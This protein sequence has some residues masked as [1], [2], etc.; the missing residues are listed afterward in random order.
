MGKV[1]ST[2]KSEIIRLAKK[3]VRA[4][5]RPLTREVRNMRIKLSRLSKNVSLFDR[6]AKE[7]MRQEESKKLKL[8][9]PPEQVKASRFTPQRIGK[10]RQRLALSQRELAM[11]TGV[12]LGAVGSWEKGKFEPRGDKKSA[13]LALKKLGRRAVRKIL[14]EKSA[15]KQE[16]K[17]VEKKTPRRKRS[18]RPRKPVRK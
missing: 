9:V 1:E 11:L 2:I 17:P 13:L 15:K 12:S 8:E 4:V 6:L 10:L 7:Q 14:E 18:R 5:F 16:K 3:E